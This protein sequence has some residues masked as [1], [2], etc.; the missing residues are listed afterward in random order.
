MSMHLNARG[1]KLAQILEDHSDRYRVQLSQTTQGTRI[2]DAGI[3][4]SGG[5]E[6]GLMLARLCLADLGQVSLHP[7]GMVGCPLVQVSSDFPIAACLASQYAGWQVSVGKYFA[8]GSGPM[9]AASGR[10]ELFKTI[11]L[12]EIA[13]AAVGV[14]ETNTIPNDDVALDITSKCNVSQEHMTLVVA[15]TSSIAGT[16]QVVARCV[17]T[18]LH[19]LHELKFDV[20]QVRYGYGTAPMPPVARKTV[21]AIG[22]TN[23]AILYGGQVTLWVDCEDDVIADIGPKVPSSSSSDYGVPFAELF[24]KV[25]GDFYKIDPLLFSPAQVKFHNLKTG[26]SQSFGAINTEMLLKSFAS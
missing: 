23:D 21:P 26:R 10:E 24:Q 5:L 3:Q 19:K 1:M 12:T 4:A 16:L 22:R 8:M 17:E 6:A 18:C 7:G 2:I 14:L 13:H 20:M 25:G 15:P 9:R 11:G